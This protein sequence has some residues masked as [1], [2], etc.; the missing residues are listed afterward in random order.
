M[1]KETFLSGLS[2][3][4][5]R[6]GWPTRHVRRIMQ[7]VTDHWNELE[8]EGRERGLDQAAASDFAWQRL[9]DPRALVDTYESTMC[10]ASWAGR[11]P[12]VSFILLPPLALLTWFLCWTAMAAGASELY[13]KLL[14]L[15]APDWGSYL[16]V[17]FGV[18]VIHYT[19]VFTVPIFFWWWARTNFRGL[20]WRW[21]ACAMCALHGMLN[22]VTVRPHLLQWGYGIA[23]VEWLPVLAPLL[24]A[25]A[26]HAFEQPGR[27][28][29]LAALAT[30]SMILAGC[31]SSKTP[32]HRGWIGG[33]Y[34]PVKHLQ[35]GSRGLLV[36][37]LRTNTP[38]ARS[39]LREGDLIVRA[40]GKPVNRMNAFHQAID[41]TQPG[42]NLS[43]GVLRDGT[44]FDVPVRAGRE[45]FTPTR[46]IVVGLL[47]SDEWDP[48]PNPSFS[49]VALG[50]KREHK[51]LDLDSPEARFKLAK[52]NDKDHPSLRSSEGWEIWLPVLSFSNRK[53][54]L[55]QSDIE[56]EP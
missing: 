31:S 20:K 47:L 35:D 17:L 2:A 30:A 27:M 9:G 53:R 42:S 54:I 38:A 37:A 7:E 11:H 32:Q 41:T 34:K 56:A 8:Q 15:N 29:A 28:R 51:R 48:W 16:T 14:G 52:T 24:V 21:I 49:L 4:M 18:K 3:R 40:A 46:A 22:Q 25:V 36:T 33:E 5:A 55:S 43:V 10:R 39:G 50:Y 45:T 19:G 6:L 13:A 44:V 1:P 23:P 26:A 12:I